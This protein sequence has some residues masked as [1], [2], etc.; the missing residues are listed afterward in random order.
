MTDTTS[1]GG[2]A[3][4]V[5]AATYTGATAHMVRIRAAH[6]GD[7]P[8]VRLVGLPPEHVW[9]TRDRLRAALTHSGLT[10]PAG[11]LT[12]TVFPH[13]L[14]VG[15]SGLDLAFALALL[16]ATGQLP[17]DRVTALACLSELGLDG[18]PRPVPGLTARA[19]AV[20]A[21]A[22]PNTVVAADDLPAAVPILGG[23][24]QAASR[25]ADL[26]AALRGGTSV[27]RPAAWL[28]APTLAGA[29]LAQVA[30]DHPTLHGN[31]VPG[32]TTEE[33]R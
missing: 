7:E 12:V 6:A 24:V 1:I 5:P 25:L 14:Q 33:V 32:D 17:A 15:D 8:G 27:Q 28:V 10:Y 22:I 4:T 19:R 3:V 30:A 20:A 9:T 2:P 29:D 13:D 21:A 31:P 23:S 11:P 26:V 16:A 18:S